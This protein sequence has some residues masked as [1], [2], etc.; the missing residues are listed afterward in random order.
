MNVVRTEV[1]AQT[2]LIT[3]QVSQ[4]DYQVKVAA[5]LEKYRKQAKNPG[6][7]PGKVPMALVQKQYGRGVLAEE[8]NKLVSDA[9][10]KYIGET[11]LEILGNPIPKEGT[12][13][14]GDFENPSD[15]EFTYEIG[16]APKIQLE[17]S[18]K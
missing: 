7:R 17:L 5:T 15:F 12:E 18:S 13:V 11:K 1:D 6:F 16:Y 10:Y 3:V 2:A 14:K 9:L 8:M 4:A